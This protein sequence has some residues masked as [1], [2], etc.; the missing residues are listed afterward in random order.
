ML[1]RVMH[2]RFFRSTALFVRR[3][4]DH[5][6][7]RDSA[8][9]TYYLLFA[10]FPLLIFISTLLGLLELTEKAGA[11]VEGIGIAV[12][13]GFQQGGELIRSKGIQLE[14]LAIVESMNS[15]TGEIKF[16]EQPHQN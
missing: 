9:L 10:I 4:F 8:A 7:A 1:E 6:V 15:E 13:K 3:Y 12:E 5:R 16:R 11:A 2:N 14:S